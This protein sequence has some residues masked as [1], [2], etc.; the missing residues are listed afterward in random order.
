MTSSEKFVISRWAYS[1][2]EPIIDDAEYTALLEYAKTV[3]ELEEFVNRS[4]SSDPCPTSLLVKYD[5]THLITDMEL[6]EKTASINSLNDWAQIMDMFGNMSTPHVVSYKHDGWNLQKRYVG[7][8]HA[9]T[10]TRGRSTAGALNIETLNAHSIP[11]IDDV[12][13]IRIVGEGTLT[14]AAFT[15]LKFRNP[16]KNLRSQRAAVR[17][18]MVTETDAG[19]VTFTAFDIL[20]ATTDTFTQKLVKLYRWGFTLP[21]FR[22][23]RNYDE[24]VSAVIELSDKAPDYAHPTDGLVVRA[25]NGDFQQAVRVMY[26]EE[27]IYRSFVMGYEESYGPA[28]ISLKIVI[29]PITL[30]NSTQTKIPI[31]NISRI[32]KYNLEIGAPIAFRVVSG[33]IAD[34]DADT[35]YVLHKTWEDRYDEYKETIKRGEEAKLLVNRAQLLKHEV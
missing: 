11:E 24:L 12:A 30:A 19:L 32:V 21:E 23:V 8:K 25:D 31:T 1:L 26:W 33:A 22:V 4:W 35:T 29:Y 15:E 34:F 18:A 6:L 14:T 28:Y 20:D 9:Y 2:G 16:E 13:D 10:R 17:T 3:P 27:P 5:Y 7:G